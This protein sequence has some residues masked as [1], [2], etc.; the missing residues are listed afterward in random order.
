MNR[1]VGQGYV[2]LVPGEQGDCGKIV[3]YVDDGAYGYANSDPAVLSQVLTRKY[4]L[5]EEWMSANKLVINPDK[6]NLVVM[7]TMKIEEKR[8]Q[9]TIQAGEFKI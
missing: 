3:G 8:K 7:G 1:E 2:E 5:L 9:V 6:T 4:N